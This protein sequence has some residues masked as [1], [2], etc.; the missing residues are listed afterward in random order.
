MRPKSEP[1]MEEKWLNR[2]SLNLLPAAVALC[3]LACTLQLCDVLVARERAQLRRRTEAEAKHVAGQLQTGLLQRFDPLHRLGAWW[4]SQGR[5]LAPEDWRNDAQ[6]FLS[7][8]VGLKQ[9]TW[10]GAKGKSL[11][12]VRP[13]AFPKVLRRPTPELTGLVAAARQL[14]AVAISSLFSGDDGRQALYACAPISRRGR[15]VGYVVGLYATS[16]LLDS[17]L[18]NQLPDDFSLLITGDGRPVHAFKA[19]R[20]HPWVEGARTADIILP[21]AAWS[22][23]IVPSAADIVSL[24]KLV[25]S[26]GLLV[27]GLLYICT[28]MGSV[29]HR[30]AMALQLANYALQLEIGERQRTEE[31]V[32]E[33]NRDLQRR[34][35]DFQTLI[36]VIPVGIAVSDDPQCAHIWINPALA[37]MMG[38][39]QGQNIS[40]T[41]PDRDNLEYKLCRDGQEVPGEEL[42]MQVAART[43]DEVIGAELDIVRPDGRV[44]NTLSFSAPLFDEDGRVRGVLDACAEI[45]ERKQAEQALRDSE[46]RYRLLY[47]LAE[48]RAAELA[49]VIESIPDAVYIG[50]T[51]GLSLCNGVGLKLLGASTFDQL[52]EGFT[53]L[54]GLFK[55]ALAG[56]NAAA[57][58]R[59]PIFP[60]AEWRNGHRGGHRQAGQYR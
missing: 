41:G 43:G 46:K 40:K 47:V 15:I 52:H 17:I 16:E 24:R 60:C 5:P 45:T 4:L 18:D 50:N 20:Q 33:L 3:G 38:V 55:H 42:P 39:P 36:D 54:D 25:M 37:K 57:N 29:S 30:R 11:W 51:D 19:P 22:A 12:S 56:R 53:Q 6:L 28:A 59:V 44:I 35:V 31:K 49:A 23:R 21:N 34:L 8:S 32:A 1:V 48:R 2:F 26:F 27:T 58:R 13:G 14:N 7:A 9:V 10:I